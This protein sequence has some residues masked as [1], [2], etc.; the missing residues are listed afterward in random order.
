MQP[1]PNAETCRPC[2]PSFCCSIELSL[3]SDTKCKR[4]LYRRL[5]YL[6]SLTVLGLSLPKPDRIMPAHFL[7]TLLLQEGA[8]ALKDLI[9]IYDLTRQEVR[10]IFETTADLKANP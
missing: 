9:S 10:R 4:T 5:V 3:L 6:P 7:T 2:V 1:K 8:L